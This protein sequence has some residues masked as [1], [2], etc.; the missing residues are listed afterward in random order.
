[1][2][3]W[4][5]LL[6]GMA[7]IASYVFTANGFFSILDER[8]QRIKFHEKSIAEKVPL[9]FEG[10]GRIFSYDSVEHLSSHDEF[11]DCERQ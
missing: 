3:E 8:L 5:F 11:S 10:S 4:T 9:H 6:C 7:K 1:M 2:R